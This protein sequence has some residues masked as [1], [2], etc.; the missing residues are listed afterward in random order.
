MPA[1]TSTRPIWHEIYSRRLKVWS[2]IEVERKPRRFGGRQT[3]EEVSPNEHR[4]SERAIC[5][6]LSWIP[7][8]TPSSARL[9]M[10]SSPVGIRVQSDYLATPA[11]RPWA[12]TLP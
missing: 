12:S 1:A 5:W 7:P 9:W 8:T 10:A 4:L 6:L 2:Q 3:H 11:K